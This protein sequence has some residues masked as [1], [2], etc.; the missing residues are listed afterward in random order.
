[1]GFLLRPRKPVA[2][3]REDW[4]LLALATAKRNLHPVQL[5]KLLTLLGRE[6]PKLTTQPFY[7]FGSISA[8]QFS[9]ELQREANLLAIV[10][11]LAVDVTDR[12]SR[13]YRLTQSGLERARKLESGADPD[14]LAFLRRTAAWVRTRSVDQL[15]NGPAEPTAAAPTPRPNPPPLGR[16]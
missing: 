3:G 12:G 1:M 11:Q 10:G 16:R 9:L 4:I 14:A 5:Q 7:N 13:E 15:M 6:F 8:G 2:L